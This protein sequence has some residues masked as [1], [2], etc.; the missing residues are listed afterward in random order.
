[1][2]LNKIPCLDKGY[3]ALIDAS[4]DSSKLRDIAREYFNSGDWSNHVDLASLTLVFHCPLFVQLFISAYSLSI[5]NVPPKDEIRAYVPNIGDIG[6]PNHLTSKDIV[7]SMEQTT[8][9]LLMNPK[10]YQM[11][12]C[13]TFT[14]QI[15]MPIS[16]YTTIIVHGSYNEW[17]RM[18][19]QKNMPTSIRA[20][21]EAV[22]QIMKAEWKNG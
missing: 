9:A 13:E 14:S 4:C 15:L 10:A 21:V 22:T 2:L 5:K 11:D 20:Y 8:A 7:H 6:S 12:G 19:A 3:V 1:M 16:T 17:R 18:C